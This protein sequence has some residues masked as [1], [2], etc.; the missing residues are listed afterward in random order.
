MKKRKDTTIA[1]NGERKE[2]LQEA[3]VEITIATRETIKPSTIVQYLIDNYLD[4][5]TKDLKGK[6]KESA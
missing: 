2:A 6:R 5:A 4:E 3:A 1:I